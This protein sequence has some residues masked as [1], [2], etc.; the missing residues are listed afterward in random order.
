MFGFFV[1]KCEAVHLDRYVL[2]HSLL[3]VHQREQAT[4]ACR[5]QK[6]TQSRSM[7]E[8]QF[9]RMT[10]DRQLLTVVLVLEILGL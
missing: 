10:L 9:W 1:S 6:M 5:L 7:A 3:V 4:A 8:D 2:V